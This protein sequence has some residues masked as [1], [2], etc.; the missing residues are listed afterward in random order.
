MLE[1]NQYL[2]GWTKESIKKFFKMNLQ[3]KD[4]VIVV[5]RTTA[6]S[7]LTQYQ[8]E[9][10]TEVTNRNF[11]ISRPVGHNARSRSFYYNGTSC[12]EPHGQTNVIPMHQGLSQLI[13]L[14]SHSLEQLG[15]YHFVSDEEILKLNDEQ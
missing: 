15:G 4:L 7:D 2:L 10:V 13:A 1:F 12:A 14:K 5:T 3:P 9:I 11:K 8:L 6:G